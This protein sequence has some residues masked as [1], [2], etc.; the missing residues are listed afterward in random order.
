MKKHGL[1]ERRACRLLGL[2]RSGYR[3]KPRKKPDDE[4]V[5]KVLRQ[6]AQDHPRWGARKMAAY[7]KNQ[8]YTWNHKR[9]ARVYKEQGLGLNGRKRTR[10]TRRQGIRGK[11]PSG[12]Q[13]LTPASYL[14]QTWSLDFMSDRLA[15]GRTFRTLNV[16]DDFSR[17]A[18]WIEVAVSLPSQRVIGLL[19]ALI[20]WHGQPDCLR[21]DNGP[22]F[23]SKA[24]AAWVE[25]QGICLLR[26]QP[27]KPAQNAYIERF[28]RSYREAVLDAY[29]FHSLAEVRQ[30]T[31]DWLRTYNTVRPHAALGGLPPQEF[32]D[33]YGR[34]LS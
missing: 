19:E 1:S 9:I 23:T 3:Y 8:G 26:I 4:E 34:R 14:N 21:T 13:P 18:L 20:L 11:L 25:S 17:Q 32:A 10:R 16:I 15:S 31:E 27:G 28:N 12:P 7:L 30:V 29:V 33:K 5:A 24:L 6:L 2:S 22:E